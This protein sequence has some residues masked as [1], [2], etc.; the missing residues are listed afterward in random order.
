MPGW[1]DKSG[2]SSEAPTEDEEQ[3]PARKSSH[4]FREGLGDHL[5]AR[6]ELLA[7]E[8]SEARELLV[9]R[10]SLAV[11]ATILLVFA[12]A[13]VLITVISLLGRWVESLSSQLNGLGWQITALVAGFLHLTLSLLLF[14]KLKRKQELNLFEFTRAE[15]KKDGKWLNQGKNSSNENESSS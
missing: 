12:Y 13:L 15:I 6:A 4:Q 5:K 2:S 3:S 10:G 14:R 11:A 1:F 9:R 7:V 8:A